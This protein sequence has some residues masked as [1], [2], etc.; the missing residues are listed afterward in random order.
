MRPLLSNPNFNDGMTMRDPVPGTVPRDYT[1]FNYTIDPESRIKAGIE[2]VNPYSSS[3]ELLAEGKKVYIQHSVSDVMVNRAQ[4]TGP[5]IKA[6]CIPWS[7]G[8]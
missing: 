1:P 7:P 8:I 3:G 6:D 4:V 2:L 5:C